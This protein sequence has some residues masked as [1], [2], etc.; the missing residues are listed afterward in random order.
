M[1]MYKGYYMVIIQKPLQEAINNE[2]KNADSA[3]KSDG[4][5]SLNG[6]GKNKAAIIIEHLSTALDRRFAILL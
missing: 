6:L 3:P 1:I 4:I 2:S 5:N